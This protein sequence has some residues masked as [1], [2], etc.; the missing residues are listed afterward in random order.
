MKKFSGN[1]PYQLCGKTVMDTTDPSI[2]FDVDGVSNHYHDFHRK[3]RPHWH[4]NAIGMRALELEVDKIKKAARGKQFDCLL[5]LSGGLDSSYM[6]HMMVTRFGLRPLV[7][8]VDGGWNSETAV[9]NI[10]AIL[11]KLDLDLYTEVIDWN[12]MRD[13]QLAW[14][15][16]GLPHIDV[17]QDHA[18]IAVLYRFAERYGIKT[19]LNGGNISTECVLTPLRY[20]YWGTD[21]RHIRD[22][23]KRFCPN[24]MINYPFSSVI[25]HKLFLRYVKGVKVLKPLNMM[26]YNKSSATMT[27]QTEYGWKPYA[28]KH[29]ESRFTRFFEGF[30]LP[31]RFNFD[32]RRVQFSS[33]ILTEQ[34][35]RDDALAELERPAIDPMDLPRDLEFI[36]N[37]LGL[38]LDELWAYHDMPRKYY[39]DYLNQHWMFASAERIMR[40]LGPSRRGGAF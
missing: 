12:E 31:T 23:I 7:F 39:W 35:S 8:H 11:D 33:L 10:A 21:M 18:F 25:R 38:T 17:P 20:F 1:R 4:P 27:L 40:L 28:Q 29:F 32:I 30:W 37:K 19:I 15:K 26:P 5:G 34:M 9:H 3:V 13:F 14:L 16:S 24:P 22:I 2:S 6:L 36:A